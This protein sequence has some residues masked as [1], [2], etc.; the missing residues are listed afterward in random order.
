MSIKIEPSK[1]LQKLA[2]KSKIKK[3]LSGRVSLKKTALSFLNDADFL[4]KD[5]VADVALRTIKEYKKRTKGD[6][7]LKKAIK[8]DPRLLINRVQ[9]EIVT[10]IK[11]D[12]KYKYRGERYRWLPSDAEEPDPE[13]QLKYGN[14]YKIGEGEMPGDRFGCRCGM[15]ILTDDDEL[16]L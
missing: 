11:E 2:P 10:Q 14:I 15:E 6:D 16:N 13:H 5:D 12:V 1:M 4:D 3:L 8:K 7:D 9:N